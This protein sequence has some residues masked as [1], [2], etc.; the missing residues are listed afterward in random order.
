[1]AMSLDPI[2]G[3]RR[4]KGGHQRFRARAE[5]NVT[6]FVDVMLVL[7]I[8]FMVTAPLLTVGEIVDLPEEGRTSLPSDEESLEITVTADGVVFVQETV[9]PLDELGARLRAIA[10]AAGI[11]AEDLVYVYGDASASYGD[12]MRALA[13]ARESG[14]S[15]AGLVMDPVSRAPVSRPASQTEEQ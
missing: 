11:T 2:G 15:K 7:L 6:P 13:V 4:G 12:M 1:M 10:A 5:I 9:V 3:G 8:V 14:F